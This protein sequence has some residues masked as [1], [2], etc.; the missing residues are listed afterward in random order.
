VL[1]VQG[2][3]LL[4]LLLLEGPQSLQKGSLQALKMLGVL[5][6]LLR[7]RRCWWRVLLLVDLWLGLRRRVRLLLVGSWLG[8]PRQEQ[9][10]HLQLVPQRLGLTPLG[11]QRQMLQNGLKHQIGDLMLLRVHPQKGGQMLQGLGL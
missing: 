6:R 2:Q 8:L 5:L 9:I 7:N 3:K 10:L 4:V 1:V 11:L